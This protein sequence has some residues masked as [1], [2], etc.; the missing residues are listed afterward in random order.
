VYGLWG[1]EVIGRLMICLI[2]PLAL[3]A[4]QVGTLEGFVF[5]EA[6]GGPPRRPLTVELIEQV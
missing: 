3:V 1:F 2:L 4:P 5:R 6:D